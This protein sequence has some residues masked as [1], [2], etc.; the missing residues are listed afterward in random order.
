[1]E[2]PRPY[3]ARLATVL[4]VAVQSN[5]ATFL[6]ICRAAKGAFPDDVLRVLSDV[7]GGQQN[8]QHL[9]GVGG[10]GHLASDYQAWPEPSPV[11]YEWRFTPATAMRVASIAASFGGKV[12]CLG[13]P[14]VFA[15]LQAEGVDAVLVDRNPSLTRLLDPP[16]K[17]CVISADIAALPACL[18]QVR[19][20]VIVIDS[21][22]YLDHMRYWI[23]QA[24]TVASP[25]ASVLLS[26][27]PELTRPTAAIERETF[28]R[29]IQ[30][31]G[32]IRFLDVLEYETPLFERETLSALGIPPLPAW[33]MGDLLSMTL[34]KNPKHPRVTRP[35][36][37]DWAR[38]L[39]GSQ[40][41]A[42]RYSTAH[43]EPIRVNSIYPDGSFMLKSV[44]A[45]DPLRHKITFWTSRNRC[46]LAS[47]GLR[48]FQFLNALAG[49]ER[50]QDLLERV[51]LTEDERNSLT[52]LVALIGW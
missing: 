15:H 22:W 52:I 36:E 12:A 48:L 26:L 24:I 37:P 31:I 4:R 3:E 16:N 32:S 21:P 23:A 25:G 41:V 2:D 46:A 30:S 17:G 10:R 18:G 44:S 34:S 8:R 47:G 19:F 50:A 33:R 43:S 39:F 9:V 27:F 38:F 45:R 20:P 42:L 49:G 51:P 5:H 35:R 13:T 40:I 7:S 11:D 14:S 29:D 1:M 6:D 28:L